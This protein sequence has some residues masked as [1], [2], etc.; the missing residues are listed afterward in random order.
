M[1]RKKH[2]NNVK[3][4]ET[5]LNLILSYFVYNHFVYIY[6]FAQTKMLVSHVKIKFKDHLLHPRTKFSFYILN[7]KVI[8][9]VCT[10]Y[11]KLCI[12]K[13]E[14]CARVQ[15]FVFIFMFILRSY[16]M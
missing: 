12:G 8:K 14:T 15:V 11:C 2:K 1:I 4:T 5:N 16:S 6:K 10:L 13:F 7:I 9:G 3:S